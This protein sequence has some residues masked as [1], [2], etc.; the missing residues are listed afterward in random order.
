LLSTYTCFIARPDG[1]E[2][3]KKVEGGK[4]K[5]VWKVE[6]LAGFHAIVPRSS[7]RFSIPQYRVLQRRV[8]GRTARAV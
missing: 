2:P 8:E 6:M 5:V 4:A 1:S 7:G 3:Q